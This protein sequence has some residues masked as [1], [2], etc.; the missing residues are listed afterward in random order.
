MAGAAGFSRLMIP[1]NPVPKRHSSAKPCV[2]EKKTEWHNPTSRPGDAKSLSL[3]NLRFASPALV[4]SLYPSTPLFAR[5][6][7]RAGAVSWNKLGRFD[8][9]YHTA[10]A[11]GI[12]D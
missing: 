7:W 3:N 8:S 12:K 4:R 9:D 10:G 11:R 5:S 2:L 1:L 6:R